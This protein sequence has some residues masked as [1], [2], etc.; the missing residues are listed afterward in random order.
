[1]NLIGL[2]LCIGSVSQHT[3]THT[4]TPTP[5]ECSSAIAFGS[6]DSF[7]TWFA[8]LFRFVY[9]FQMGLM[10]LVK[11]VKEEREATTG[12]GSSVSSHPALLGN[13]SLAL[14]ANGLM[15]SSHHDDH[16]NSANASV[17]MSK[18]NGGPPSP[19]LHDA[20]PK[21]SWTDKLAPAH[22]V[23]ATTS[24]HR[25]SSFFLFRAMRVWI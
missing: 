14:G 13:D 6:I 23:R 2:F 19:H 3:H 18:R 9:C 12:C 11:S 8:C 1:M 16:S 5:R 10:F 21:E 22:K 24:N 25:S 20:E 4:H 17:P 7:V 15:S